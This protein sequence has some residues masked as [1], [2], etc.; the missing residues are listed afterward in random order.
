MKSTDIKG[1][2]VTRDTFV[3][4]EHTEKGAVLLLGKDIDEEHA[5]SLLASGKAVPLDQAGLAAKKN[6]MID[7]SKASTK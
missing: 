6:R 3:K 7:G 1:V 5:G 4:G 2:E